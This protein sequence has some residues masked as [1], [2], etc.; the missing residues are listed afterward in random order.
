MNTNEQQQ[1]GCTG[2]VERDASCNGEA[3]EKA[4]NGSFGEAVSQPVDV[5]AVMD[6]ERTI[7]TGRLRTAERDLAR[8]ERVR[9][10]HRNAG[11]GAEAMARC[12][13]D[14]ATALA[15]ATHLG[16]QLIAHDAARAAVAELIDAAAYALRTRD[17]AGALSDTAEYILRAALASC[18]VA[19]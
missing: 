18:G 4:G 13:E 15:R 7:L 11:C 1:T 5:L 10:G 17:D 9:K 2:S 16:K 3:S 12:D 14:V 19:P 6:D 8:E